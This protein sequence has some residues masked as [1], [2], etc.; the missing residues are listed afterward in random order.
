M[1]L[2]VSACLP[3]CLSLCPSVSLSACLSVFLSLCFCL[4]VCLSVC[5]YVSVCFSVYLSVCQSLSLSICLF[6][7]LPVCLSVYLSPSTCL[8]L[9]YLSLISYFT[10]IASIAH[11]LSR[12]RPA[13]QHSTYLLSIIRSQP[14]NPLPSRHRVQPIKRLSLSVCFCLS[15]SLSVC[16]CLSLFLSVCLSMPHDVTASWRY[17]RV[18]NRA[19]VRTPIIAN[20]LLNC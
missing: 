10:T 5:L 8:W 20:C 11:S 13:Y 7:C 3:I 12:S 17:R 2:S 1:S 16:L 9:M 6:V 18:F 4:S 19:Q 14:F 15:L